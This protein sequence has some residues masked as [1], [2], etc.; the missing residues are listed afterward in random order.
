MLPPPPSSL[1]P[2]DI[3]EWEDQH[4]NVFKSTNWSLIVTGPARANLTYPLEL[5]TRP[6]KVVPI[7]GERGH[8]A[9]TFHI[10]HLTNRL[11]DRLFPQLSFN[12]NYEKERPSSF[13]RAV[14]PPLLLPRPM[15][16]KV[17]HV[18]SLKES[19]IPAGEFPPVRWRSTIGAQQGRTP[20]REG[21]GWTVSAAARL[22]VQPAWWH[23]GN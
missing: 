7:P 19:I 14:T 8:T 11:T 15:W 1:S 18:G 5:E 3:K 20:Q 16:L 13:Y 2:A 23:S 9:Q 22:V 12:K 17:V 10:A 4:I 6:S 21:L